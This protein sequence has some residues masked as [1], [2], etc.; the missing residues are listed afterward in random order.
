MFWKPFVEFRKIAVKSFN[1]PNIFKII[2]QRWVVLTEYSDML[3]KII[4]IPLY[5]VVFI[6]LFCNIYPFGWIYERR[7]SDFDCR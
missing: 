7:Q 1:L 5:V 4:A 2:C 3:V 6:E